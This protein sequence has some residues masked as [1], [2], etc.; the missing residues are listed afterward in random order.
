M[1]EQTS[2]GLTDQVNDQQQNQL[3]WRA[4]LPDELKQNEVLS[5]YTNIGEVSRDFLKLK[6][7]SASMLKKPDENATEEEKTAFYRALGVPEK[8]DEY[9]I[10]RPDGMPEGYTYDEKF[11]A[12]FREVALKHK[13][14][15]GAVEGVYSDMMKY[16]FSEHEAAAKTL[17]EEDKKLETEL[18]T[19]WG[20]DYDSN[21]QKSER[22]M[23]KFGEEEGVKLLEEAGLK[24]HPAIRKLF[25]RIY[26]AIDEDVFATGSKGDTPKVKRTISGLPYLNFNNSPTMPGNTS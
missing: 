15:K 14:S 3:G 18:K 8:P 20:A 7:E 6:E 1:S 13:L 5:Q 16:I 26:E 21:V 4:A 24:N 25:H 11:E 9:E 22:A 10:K 17:Q 23:A 2:E 12:Q 19:S